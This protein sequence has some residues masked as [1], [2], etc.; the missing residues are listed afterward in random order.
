MQA[1]V[2]AAL[3]GSVVAVFA[4][5]FA[6][7]LRV[8]RLAE[9]LN[10]LKHIGARAT[11]LASERA[12]H[13]AYPASVA[14]TPAEVPKGVAVADDPA[15]WEHPTWVELGFRPAQPHYFSFQFISDNAR[16][17]SRFTA[18]A[19]GDLDGDGEFSRFEL[20]G[21]YLPGGEPHLLPMEIVREVE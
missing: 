4:P 9:P 1:V 10:G 16:R 17:G 7:N 18:R 8:S 19:Q 5:A 21:E 20:I 12:V 14:L 3:L 2:A 13:E 6:K 11:L 15:I